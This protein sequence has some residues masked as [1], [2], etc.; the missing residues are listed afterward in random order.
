M[1]E[2]QIKLGYSAETVRLY[3]PLDSLNELLGAQE[4]ASGMEKL[5]AQF[6]EAEKEKLGEMEISRKGDR[7]CP[8]SAPGR[9]EICI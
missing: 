9:N 1:K 8:G 2:G 6:A 5:L 7:F 3:Y 4:D